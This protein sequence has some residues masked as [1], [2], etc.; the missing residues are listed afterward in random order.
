MSADEAFLVWDLYDRSGRIDVL[1]A[2]LDALGFEGFEEHADGLRAYVPE[3][4][5]DDSLR[6]GLGAVLE[7]AGVEASGPE[8]IGPTNWNAA[9]EATVQPV[10]AG[11][12]VV[13]PPWHEPPAGAL[14]I[15]IEP[16]MSFGTGHHETTRLVLGLVPEIVRPGDRVLDAG[17]GTGVL[18]IASVRIGASRAV[19]FDT[20]PW[21]VRNAVENAASNGMADRIVV[22]EGDLEAVPGE[23]FD[24]I[25]ANINRNV[26]LD[27][28]PAF[29]DRLDQGGRLALSGVLLD[30]RDVMVEALDSS[31]FQAVVERTEGAW[32]SVAA[33]RT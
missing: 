33:V 28:V 27:L 14:A 15:R 10:L 16:K 32:W 13:H 18:A 31:G 7:R 24:V 1:V 29:A 2:E 17:T 8:R 20:D 21:S 3:R 4:R 11:P 19:G 9:W 23:P 25:L 5:A 30:D 12:F 26:L 6:A 22:L